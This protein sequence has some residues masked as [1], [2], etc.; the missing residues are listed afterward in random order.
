M[1]RRLAAILAADVVGYSRLMEQDEVDT[2]TRL[3]AH[4]KELFEPEIGKHNGRIFKLMGDGLLAEFGSVV[5]AVECAVVLQR[6]MAERNAGIAKHQRIDV[7]IG[8]NLGDVIVEGEDR[9]GDGVNIAARLQQVA[10]PGGI[11]VSRTVAEHVKH[12]LAVRF[13]S[14][15]EHRVKNIAEPVSIHR[16]L[17]DG[18][19]AQPRLLLWLAHLRRRRT[20]VAA[21]TLVLPITVGALVWNSYLRR[22][23]CAPPVSDKPSIAVLPFDNLGNDEKW[24]RLADGFTEAVITNL[25]RSRDLFVIAGNSTRIYKGSDVDVREVGCDLGVTYV[26]D[27]S[28]QNLGDKI[29][30]TPHLIKTA[31]RHLV[32]SEPFDRTPEEI[33]QIQD[34]VTTGIAGKV[35]GYEGG[36]PQEEIQKIRRKPP[37][38]NLEAYDYYLRAETLGRGWSETQGKALALYQKA[39][40][41]DPKFADAYAGYARIV[42]DAWLYQLEDIRPIPVARKEA[43]ESAGRA[44]ALDPGNPKPYSILSALQTA[45][46]WHEQAIETARKA[47]ALQPNNADAYTYLASALTYA[48]RHPEALAAMETALRMDPNSSPQ[49]RADLGW[50]LFHN[51]QYERALEQLKQAHDGGVD[52]FK[53]LAAVYVGL[54]RLSEARATVR[55]MLKITGVL[56]LEFLRVQYSHYK[57]E[58]DLDQ[59]LDAL[60]QAGLPE[61][62]FGY[63]GRPEYRLDAQEIAALAFGRTWIGLGDNGLRFVQEIGESGAFA[64]RD[65]RT[66]I[67]G[68]LSLRGNKLCQQT[69]AVLMGRK[70]CGYVYRNSAGTPE[71]KNEYTYVSP[72][73]SFRFSVTP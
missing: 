22:P 8:V 1:E 58:E 29:R 64:Y 33:F 20:V 56:S 3:R 31:N 70:H 25:S 14:L 24:S 44:L 40:A 45:D 48:G 38:E 27:G 46:G 71:A 4:R 12:K 9:H 73:A 35:L 32:W 21:L 17:F 30:V 59:L 63:Q 60:R 41:L 68:R 16:V 34:D 23:P 42:A 65:S 47:I 50:V 13:D 37:T 43:Y 52:D 26:L 69:E 36:M 72:Y 19:A 55:Q 67:T 15:G 18:T 49:F 53:T 6:G 66:L 11:C 51:R 7:R 57:R 54:G 5:D 28:I 39:I 10:E 61:W 62:P 2:F